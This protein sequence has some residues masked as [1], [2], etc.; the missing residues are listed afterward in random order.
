L[1]PLVQKIFQRILEKEPNNTEAMMGLAM[2]TNNQEE[3][4]AL[5]KGWLARGITFPRSSSLSPP[6][7][8]SSFLSRIY[9]IQASNYSFLNKKKD[10]QAA[11]SKAIEEGRDPVAKIALYYDRGAVHMHLEQYQEAISDYQYFLKH[12]DPRTHLS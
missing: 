10:A 7:T 9:E 8:T 3:K 4:A 2:H 5:V 1:L 11:Y 6:S 12:A